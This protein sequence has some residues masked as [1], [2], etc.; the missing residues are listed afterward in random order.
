VL[1]DRVETTSG[2]VSIGTMHLAKGLEFRAVAVMAVG[3]E[4]VPLLERIEAVGDDADLQEVRYRAAAAVR[5][6]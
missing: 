1:D 2:R 6:L 5:G 3:D 4:V